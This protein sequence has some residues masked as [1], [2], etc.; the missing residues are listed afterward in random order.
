MRALF[1][2]SAASGRF[3]LKAADVIGD[4]QVIGGQTCALAAELGKD[5]V[6]VN[7]IGPGLI[8]TP[9]NEEVR[10]N[11]PELMKIFMDHTPLGRA[12]R[13]RGHRR[14]G[15]LPGLR[16]GGVRHRLDRHGRRRV[17]INLG[18]CRA[19]SPFWGCVPSTEIT[20]R[21]LTLPK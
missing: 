2:S 18:R 4:A 10:A 13:P 17:S 8:E 1:R 7:A 15:D 16:P 21:M 3:I 14:S 11:N 5:G 19:P 6:R 9:L 20:L 12:G